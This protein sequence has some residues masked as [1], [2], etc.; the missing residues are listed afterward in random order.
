MKKIFVILAAVICFGFSANAA[1]CIKEEATGSN[2]NYIKVT[3]MCKDCTFLVRVHY[4]DTN[5]IWRK[6]DVREIIANGY[7]HILVPDNRTFWVE[8]VGC[9]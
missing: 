3:N 8:E 6:T 1:W 2:H 9:K 4:E 7:I 5:G